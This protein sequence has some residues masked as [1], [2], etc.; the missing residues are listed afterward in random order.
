MSMSGRSRVTRR[1]KP[2]LS[3]TL[4]G[5][6][7][8]RRSAQ[9]LHPGQKEIRPLRPQGV[10]ERSAGLPQERGQSHGHTTVNNR[11]LPDG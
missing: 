2:E 4:S 3:M 10:A 7:A 5:P 8:R 11:M 1:E 9:M 6:I